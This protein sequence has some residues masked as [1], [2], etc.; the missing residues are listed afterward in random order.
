MLK[1]VDINLENILEGSCE[2][3]VC[4]FE[5][6]DSKEMQDGYVFPKGTRLRQLKKEGED[7]LMF[8]ETIGD[9][10]SMFWVKKDDVC[11]LEEK[12]EFFEGKYLKT[13]FKFINEIFL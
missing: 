4:Y 11:F 2:Y 12:K 5:L 7:C 6:I 9:D 1:L 13:I 3:L 10:K 8:V